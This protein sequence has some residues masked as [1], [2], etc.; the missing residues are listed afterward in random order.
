MPHP[1][2]RDLALD[3]IGVAVTDL[4]AAER[5]YVQTLGGRV[6]ARQDLD[7]DGVRAVF[8]ALGGTL[9]ELLAPAG[10]GGPLL[11]FLTSRGEGLHHLAF[12]V[13][14]LDGAL[15]E[16]AAGGLRLVDASPRPGTRGRLIAFLH[17]ST[18]RGVLIELVQ[19]PPR[20]HGAR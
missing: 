1:V 16:A 3:H 18:T 13:A 19:R 20:G 17:P 7:S 4:A 6:I 5:L 10:D 15:R 12:E 2:L 8:V 11:R 14:D 9:I